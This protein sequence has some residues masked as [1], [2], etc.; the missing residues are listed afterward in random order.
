[1]ALSSALPRQVQA[2]L[3]DRGASGFPAFLGGSEVDW[4]AHTNESPADRFE[5][6]GAELA[7][8]GWWG[9]PLRIVRRGVD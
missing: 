9:A 3:L 1:M 6:C 7:G 2:A 5:L 4:T 8:A